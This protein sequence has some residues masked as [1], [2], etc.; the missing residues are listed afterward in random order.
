MTT[1]QKNTSIS[2]ISSPL[3]PLDANTRSSLLL[4]PRDVFVLWLLSIH[5]S[6]VWHPR[7]QPDSLKAGQPQRGGAERRRKRRG[8]SRG[9]GRGG[10]E[11]VCS[12]WRH[13]TFCLLRPAQCV[14]LCAWKRC[15][16]S[17]SARWW[18]QRRS[19]WAVVKPLRGI[20]GAK[21]RLFETKRFP[22]SSVT[23][24]WN[25]SERWKLPV[26][27]RPDFQWWF[28]LLCFKGQMG[29]SSFNLATKGKLSVYNSCLVSLYLCFVTTDKEV[30]MQVTWLVC[31]LGHESPAL[32]LLL[33]LML[34]EETTAE[35]IRVVLLRF[36]IKS[37]TAGKE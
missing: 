33:L 5:Y 35:T 37:R 34:W 7:F 30:A 3:I 27:R 2:L 22:I 31:C 28:F 1:V 23:F 4:F 11:W 18:N 10:Y 36:V 29:N 9:E 14:C 6:S 15:D 26:P 25:G 20:R 24:P 8:R 12:V 19:T 21:W 17:I 16:S 32:L 13:P